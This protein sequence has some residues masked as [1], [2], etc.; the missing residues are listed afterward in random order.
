M[1]VKQKLFENESI[2]I[3][4]LGPYSFI[5]RKHV[6]LLPEHIRLEKMFKYKCVVK[7]HL[8]NNKVKIV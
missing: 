2:I 1:E 6:H 7:I 3:D 5:T 8:L 4:H